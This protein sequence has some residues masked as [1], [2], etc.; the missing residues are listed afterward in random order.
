VTGNLYEIGKVPDR[1]RVGLGGR[2]FQKYVSPLQAILSVHGVQSP[3]RDEIKLL[4]HIVNIDET[5]KKKTGGYCSHRL[6]QGLL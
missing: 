1:L 4:D 3:F 2:Y 6:V 5:N